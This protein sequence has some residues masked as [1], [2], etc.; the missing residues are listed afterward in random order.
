MDEIK[1]TA[2]TSTGM[3]HNSEENYSTKIIPVIQEQVRVD[4]KIV[5]TGKI[6]IS[7]TVQ[8][9]ETSL[10]IPLTHDE[11]EIER[12][13]QN[14][15]FETAPPPVRYE[16]DTMIIPVLREV[17][18]VEKRYELIEEVRITQRKIQTTDTQQITLRKEQVHV[19]RREGDPTQTS[20]A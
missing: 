5:E 8:E 2:E 4:K 10:N 9:Q 11:F 16:G 17:L 20:N 1:N 18:V 14:Q 15:I 7:K 12:V 6:H 19:E 3:Q 13:P